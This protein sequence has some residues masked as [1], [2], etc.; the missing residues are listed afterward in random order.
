MDESY[1][2]LSD[3]ESCLDQVKSD[4]DIILLQT[5]SK[6]YEMAGIRCGFGIRRPELLEKLTAYGQDPIPITGAAAPT[7]RLKDATLVPTSQENHR[8]HSNRNIRVAGSQQ[9]Q[10]HPFAI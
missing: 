7:A 4:K 2:H 10:V 9:L 3:A 1:I 5:F 8:R 6:I